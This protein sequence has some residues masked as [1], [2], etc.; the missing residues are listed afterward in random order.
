MRKVK[1]VFVPGV[2]IL[3]EKHDR[4][5]FHAPDEETLH[6]VALRI[7]KGR[8]RHSYW[9]V[10]PEEPQKPDY[11]DPKEIAGLRG[12]LRKT[13]EEQLARYKAE[14]AF[15]ET[16]TLRFGDIQKAI[17]T[18]DGA[19]AWKILQERSGYEYEEIVFEPYATKY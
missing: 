8:A 5:Y 2:V 12:N 16:S 1:K 9:Y 15:F 10:K 14:L 19:L 13:A 4:F 18:K 11:T 6:S 17:T 3:N 7:L